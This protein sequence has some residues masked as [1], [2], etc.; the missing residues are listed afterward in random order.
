MYIVYVCMYVACVIDHDFLPIF[1]WFGCDPPVISHMCSW[2]S[3]LKWWRCSGAH[4]AKDFHYGILWMTVTLCNTDHRSSPLNMFPQP[5]PTFVYA[6]NIPQYSCHRRI[7]KNLSWYA[8]PCGHFTLTQLDC[9]PKTFA[10]WCNVWGR[11]MVCSYVRP[12][13]LDSFWQKHWA[14]DS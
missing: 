13:P 7:N 12:V 9:V 8:S 11:S 6:H 5:Q 14:Q 3:S 2:L 10:D 1:P 4:H